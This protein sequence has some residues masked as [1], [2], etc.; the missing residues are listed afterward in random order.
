[1]PIAKYAPMIDTG[2]VDTS[3]VVNTTINWKV[4]GKDRLNVLMYTQTKIC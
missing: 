1:M 4:Q 2:I 3:M